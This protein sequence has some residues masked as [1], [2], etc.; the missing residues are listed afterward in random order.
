[1][2]TRKTLPALLALLL[3]AGCALRTEP[4]PGTPGSFEAVF[5]DVTIEAGL[6]GLPDAPAAWGD[7]DNDGL[8]DLYVSGTLWRNRGDGTFER[9]PGQPFAGA[10]PGTWGDFNNNGWLDLYCWVSHR[11]FRNDSGRGFTDVSHLLP[12]REIER[13]RS[14]A[15]LDL[16]GNGFLDLYVTGYE[17]W[18]T[19]EQWHDVAYYNED[20]ETFREAWHAPGLPAV[21]PWGAPGTPRRARGVTAADFNETGRPSLFISNYRL[22]PN[23]LLVA[24]GEG[25]YRDRAAA[26][27]AAGRDEGGVFGHTIGSAWGD[28]DNDGYLDLFIG[29]FSHPPPYQDRPQFL[30]N[31]GPGHGYRFRDMS[32]GAGLAW[33]ESYASPALADFDN[34][35]RL[36]LFFTTVYEGDWSVLYRNEG[37]WKFRRVSGAGGAA[38]RRTYQAAWADYNGSGYPDLVSGG[39]LFR[40]NGSGNS[41]LKVR[42]RGA[43]PGGRTPFGATVLV[44]AGELLV[45]RHL[46]PSTGEGNQNDQDLL[47]GL[48]AHRDA[49]EIEVRWPGGGVTRRRARPNRLVGIARR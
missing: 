43:G 18:N 42:L 32:A 26:L 41:W 40:N 28:F 29:N 16:S 34:D 30:R 20:G 37:D 15:W 2:K 27:G 24:D 10:G 3:S 1:M 12:E 46:E 22:Q 8:V 14:A 11:L 44:R 33:Q 5:E 35:G 19:G 38:T 21:Y 7:F 31:L 47:F 9:V 25:V 45:T 13:S 49:V 4:A 36:D 23:T 17:N 48:G 39:R 6:E